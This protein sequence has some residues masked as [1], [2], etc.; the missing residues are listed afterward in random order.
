MEV[1]HYLNKADLR[2]FKLFVK[3]SNINKDEFQVINLLDAYKSGEFETDVELTKSVFPDLKMNG[4]YRLKNRMLED[5]HKSLLIINFAKDERIH[6]LNLLVLAQVFK[7]KQAFKIAFE[8]LVQAQKKAAENDLL[9]MLQFVYNEIISLS[10][11]YADIPL[12]EYLDKKNDIAKKLVHYSKAKDFITIISYKLKNLSDDVSGENIIDELEN[13]LK[14]LKANELLKQS[15]AI[16]FQVNS[17]V[18]NI[19]RQKK[20]YE[21]IIS[22]LEKSLIDFENDGLFTKVHFK[23]K[24]SMLVWIIN[25]NLS[26][27]KFNKVL[28]LSEQLLL[29]INEYKGLYYDTYIWTYYQS[30]FSA[31]FYLG[32][33][34]KCNELL[35]T[36]KKENSVDSHSYYNLFL[37]VNNVVVQ[38]CLGNIKKAMKA[39]AALM[40]PK[41]LLAYSS[42]IRFNFIIVDLILYYEN[43]DF[44]FLL[45]QIKEVKRK[46]NHILKLD[47][48]AAEKKFLNLLHKMAKAGS[49][50][51][52]DALIA[53][54]NAF[55][56]T[57]AINQKRI[58]SIKYK[59]WLKAK[60][61]KKDYYT[62]LTEDVVS[63]HLIK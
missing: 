39:I 50:K 58:S 59:V 6:I 49:S 16:R 44:D 63:W 37:E 41:V 27:Y 21:A 42:D 54:I 24:L 51:W 2:N 4:F 35:T 61:L 53:N 18:R 8:L 1:V 34:E 57:E 9:E 29:A 13:I 25:A 38:Y 33:I 11:D 47:E 17:V 22:Y 10:L 52:G 32:K 30:V 56:E 48:M 28:E 55:I 14:E 26:I 45:Y 7:Y 62:V 3:R 15:I 40:V 43:K 23:H 12:F 19:L 60:L 46:Y 36:W 5:I 31:S 20:D